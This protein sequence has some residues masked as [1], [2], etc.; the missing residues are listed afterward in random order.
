MACET[1]VRWQE[2]LISTPHQGQDLLVVLEELPLGE[3]GHEH[4]DIRG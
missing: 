3:S 1:Q 4:S 2:L